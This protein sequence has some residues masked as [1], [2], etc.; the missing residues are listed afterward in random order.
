MTNKKMF[1]KVYGDLPKP[2]KSN[3]V[4]V[5]DDEPYSWYVVKIEVDANTK[6]SKKMLRMLKSIDVI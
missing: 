6:L 3:V 4:C 2:E 1:L 5:I